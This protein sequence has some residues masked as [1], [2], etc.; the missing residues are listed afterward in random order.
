MVQ[1]EAFLAFVG[2]TRNNGWD[3]QNIPVANSV[4]MVGPEMIPGIHSIKLGVGYCHVIQGDRSIM[5][6]AG[7]PGQAPRFRKSMETLG[8]DPH[9]IRLIVITHGHWDHIGSAK[10]IQE[11]T[12]TKIAMHH[13]ETDW[14]ENPMQ[15]LSPAVT[16]WG[17][18]FRAIMTPLLPLVRFPA[19][20]VDVIWETKECL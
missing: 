18:V 3:A 2:S 19:T 12:G 6:D 1:A 14:L 7:S 20:G 16:L 9:G 5:I 4:E 13:W 8:I 10:D 17:H 15:V 11:M